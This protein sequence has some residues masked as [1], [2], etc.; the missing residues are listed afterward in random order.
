[1]VISV[2][3]GKERRKGRRSASTSTEKKKPNL[4]DG[5]LGLRKLQK[6][7]QRK[8]GEDDCHTSDVIAGKKEQQ[9]EEFAVFSLDNRREG[10]GRKTLPPVSRERRL[11]EKGG[12]ITSERSRSISSCRGGERK[13]ATA[14]HLPLFKGEGR[15][16]FRGERCSCCLTPAPPPQRRRKGEEGRKKACLSDST[17]EGET[18]FVGR[19]E[20]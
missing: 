2:F 8:K 5:E 20:G 14:L 4:E 1:M 11:Q 13:R 12:K 9:T 6:L 15:N 7:D 3:A 10:R 18:T 17:S 19:R 16:S